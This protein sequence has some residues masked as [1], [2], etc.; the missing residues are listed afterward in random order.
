M[1]P[2]SLKKWGLW[3]VAVIGWVIAAYLGLRVPPPPLPLDGLPSQGWV[4]D[5][6]A[7]AEVVSGLEFKTFGDTP[8]GKV[9]QGD[10]PKNVYLWQNHKKLTG[11]NP[12]S[13][14]QGQVGSCVSFGTNTAVERTYATEIALRGGQEFRFFVEE[15]TYGGSRVEVG[16]GRLRG[17]G[18]VGA[19]AADF[20]KKWGMVARGVHGQH[21]L[22]AYSESLARRYGSSGVPDDLERVAK[23]H[24]VQD[25][26]TVRDWAQAKQA[27]A[28][29]YAIA[30]CSNQGFSSQ[31][32]AN[33]VCKASGSWAHCM[34]LD[35]YHVEA[36]G[37]EY[38]HIENSWGTGYHKGP[39]GWGDPPPSGFW[40]ASGT[41]D[42]MLRGG[43]SWAFASVKG[44]PARNKDFDWYVRV[45]RREVPHATAREVFFAL[46]P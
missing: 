20:V 43:D 39:L 3:L 36:G 2:E 11:Q 5:P 19:W 9:V 7:V 45:P 8:A 1:S 6:A 29:G 24:P 32:D 26:T 13:K 4:E 22:T 18:S 14:N 12:P 17:D 27:L 21:D 30:I 33:G 31:R 38:G 42:R 10:L 40:A 25:V 37:Q 23:E 16:G 46:A 41:I 35:G 28:S 44:W 34:A 15:V